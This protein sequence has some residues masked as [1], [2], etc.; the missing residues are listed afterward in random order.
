M[1]RA[2]ITA[3]FAF[4]LAGVA[5]HQAP[6]EPPGP[7]AVAPTPT[8]QPT[9]HA[10]LTGT[11]IA[12]GVP[13]P[14]AQVSFLGGPNFGRSVVTDKL[15]AFVLSDLVPGDATVLAKKRSYKS[16]QAKVTLRDDSTTSVAIN[17]GYS[18]E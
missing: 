10:T 17:L 6:T 7:R 3:L 16:N 9:G 13:A 4:A 14:D 1:K 8:P 18:L 15:G 12:G 5:C 11:V 2:L